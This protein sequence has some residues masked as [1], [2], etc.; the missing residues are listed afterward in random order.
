MSFSYKTLNSNDIA[1]TSYIANKQWEVTDATL[2]QNGVTIY[3]GENLPIN[4]ANPFDPTNDSQT[5]NEE[6]RRLVFDSIKNLYYQN[7]VSG[8]LSGQ[9][10]QSSSFFN[11]EQSTLVSGTIR[12]LPT[13][14]GSSAIANNPT[15]YGSSLL[16]N[17]LSQYIST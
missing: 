17:A 7:Y 14:T 16:S 13:I 10:F 3:I 1:L 2:S 4:K 5:E 9:F 6:Y 8:T 12:N 15:L 11:Y